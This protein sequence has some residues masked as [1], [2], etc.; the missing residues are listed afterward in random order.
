M[1]SK[2][3]VAYKP[4]KSQNDTYQTSV[5]TAYSKD[6]TTGEL[7][8]TSGTNVKTIIPEMYKSA[9]LKYGGTAIKNNA[10]AKAYTVPAGKVFI[11]C[12]A[13]MSSCWTNAAAYN[14]VA[15]FY[16][17]GGGAALT[18]FFRVQPSPGVAGQETNTTTPS[19]TMVYPEGCYFEVNSSDTTMYCSGR[20]CGYEID[21]SEYLGVFN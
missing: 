8:K 17:D 21:A 2:K 20:V 9:V 19:I 11:L 1:A 13:Q 6:Q 7:F 12:W 18:V 10:S 16:A 15:E 4:I 5:S 14:D 3:F